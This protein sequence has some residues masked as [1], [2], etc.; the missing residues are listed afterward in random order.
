MWCAMADS[1][2]SGPALFPIAPHLSLSRAPWDEPNFQRGNW[3]LPPWAM[4]DGLLPILPAPP[5]ELPAPSRESE[6]YSRFDDD[7]GQAPGKDDPS[8]WLPVYEKEKQRQWAPRALEVIDIS[9]GPSPRPADAAKAS[10][11]DEPSGE[12]VLRR[13]DVD[14]I[15]EEGGKSAGEERQWGPGRARRPL[16]SASRMSAGVAEPADEERR[17]IR[18]VHKWWMRLQERVRRGLG[19]SWD[20][21]LRPGSREERVYE[22]GPQPGTQVDADGRVVDAKRRKRITPS[23]YSA[24]EIHGYFGLIDD[25]SCSQGRMLICHVPSWVRGQFLDVKG[26][27]EVHAWHVSGKT[28]GVLTVLDSGRHRYYSPGARV[29][30]CTICVPEEQWERFRIV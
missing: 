12:I 22:P 27:D 20:Y 24:M 3:N 13:G 30:T 16:P 18:G 23:N 19:A 5:G 17:I 10:S 28:G 9:P 1:N 26:G 15:V 25:G 4:S 21:L 8:Q 29:T 7:R 6:G 2:A 11:D 14:S